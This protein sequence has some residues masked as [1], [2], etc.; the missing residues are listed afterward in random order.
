[1]PSERARVAVLFA[2]DVRVEL[3]EGT[4]DDSAITKFVAK[5]GP[6][7]HHLAFKV[8]DCAESIVRLSGEGMQLLD[9]TPRPGAHHTKVTFVH[10]K[11]LMGVLTELVE[12]TR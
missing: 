7:V 4:G 9:E 1:V 8:G 5:R 12:E 10:P 6:G 2:G 11:S 3:L